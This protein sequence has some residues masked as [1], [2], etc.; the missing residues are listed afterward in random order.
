MLLLYV[1]N[2]CMRAVNMRVTLHLNHNYLR[3]AIREK[4]IKIF[5]FKT[6]KLVKA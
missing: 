4:V 3:V 5:I 2:L 6:R 1:Y